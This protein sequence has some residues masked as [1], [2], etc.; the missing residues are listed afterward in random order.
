MLIETAAT[1]S[2]RLQAQSQYQPYMLVDIIRIIKTEFNKIFR[3]FFN[4]P[5]SVKF[6]QINSLI[7][8]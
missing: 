3:Q 4:R 5:I 8:T 2:T 6:H 7:R 1:V